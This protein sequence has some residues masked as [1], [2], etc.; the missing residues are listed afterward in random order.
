M[1][2]LTPFVILKLGP[3]FFSCINKDLGLALVTVMAFFLYSVISDYFIMLNSSM[4]IR[5]Y[6]TVLA[7]MIQVVIIWCSFM[8]VL[9]SLYNLET[10]RYVVMK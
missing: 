7:C 1:S 6:D 3:D 2:L 10:D 8:P 9:P 4:Y 5:Y